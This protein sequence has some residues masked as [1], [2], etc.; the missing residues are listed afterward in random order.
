MNWRLLGRR[1]AGAVCATKRLIGNRRFDC[2]R[3]ARVIYISSRS[4]KRTLVIAFLSALSMA[5]ATI[6]VTELWGK[7]MYRVPSVSSVMNLTALVY[8][9]F[10]VAC[11]IVPQLA[12]ALP[13]KLYVLISLCNVVTGI[14]TVLSESSY[15][16]DEPRDHWSMLTASELAGTLMLVHMFQFTPVAEAYRLKLKITHAR[17]QQFAH[18]VELGNGITIHTSQPSVLAIGPGD[19]EGA[20]D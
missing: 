13:T 4:S 16:P 3:Q 2:M 15:D 20:I 6:V 1:I 5:W 17:S 7:D 14:V 18:S 8:D 11:L 19:D 10:I 9:C 12:A